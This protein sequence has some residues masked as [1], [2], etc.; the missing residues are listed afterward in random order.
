MVGGFFDL[1]EGRTKRKLI[2]S[3]RW[4]VLILIGLLCISASFSQVP[5][6]SFIFITV[7]VLSLLAGIRWRYVFLRL[8]LL[9]PFGL[10]A[11]FLLPFSIEGEI[12]STLFDFPISREGLATA[13]ILVLKLIICHFIICLLLGTTTSTQL[14]NTLM[15]IGIPK[16][17]IDI[18]TF[19]LRYLSVLFEE[20]ERMILAQLSRG[21]TIKSFSSWSSY[22]RSGELLGVLF[23][24]SYERSNRIHQAMLARGM[25]TTIQKEVTIPIEC[26]SNPK[27]IL[28]ISKFNESNR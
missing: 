11:I 16:V 9:L 20:I 23:I 8:I 4:R 19:T 5:I 13:G 6:L 17:L 22:K 25:G 1:S 2:H 10:G 24:R 7:I 14:L 3:D 18:I 27:S 21:L 28:S 26:H 12:V 15:D